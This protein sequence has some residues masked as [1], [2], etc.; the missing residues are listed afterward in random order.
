MSLRHLGTYLLVFLIF[1][2]VFVVSSRFM[3][4]E[5]PSNTPDLRGVNFRETGYVKDGDPNNF[6]GG[7]VLVYEKPG[8]PALSVE[9]IL[10]EKSYCTF[11]E[12]GILC[13]ALS[14][15]IETA[16]EGRRVLVEGVRDGDQVFVRNLEIIEEAEK[17][18]GL[19]QSV[20]E[21]SQNVLVEMDEVEFLSGE[22]A[23]EA[24]IDDT[25]CERENI[26]DCIPSMNNDFYIRNVETSTEVYI[27]NDNSEIVLFENPGSPEL[28]NVTLKEFLEQSQDEDRF[29]TAYPYIY[30]LDGAT[31]VKLEE[32]Y[33]P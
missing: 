24:G 32:Q 14:V 2:V 13:M 30:F 19:I 9:L 17:R 29:I 10:N 20:R 1:G 15:T 33:V 27:L 21:N 4:V 23:I 18:F 8:A 11:G 16:L 25:E 31:I 6:G 3:E 28:E 22:E 5:S 7:L 26:Y 12:Q